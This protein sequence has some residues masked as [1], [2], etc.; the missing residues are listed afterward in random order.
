[1]RF[2]ISPVSVGLPS[3]GV[4]GLR[5]GSLAALR[6]CDRDSGCDPE[7][8]ARS[9]A[10]RQVTAQR[11][12]PLSHAAGA[13]ALCA[14]IGGALLGGPVVATDRRGGR[15]AP[16]VVI[17]LNYETCRCVIEAN[18]RRG[19]AGVPAYVRQRLLHDAVGSE[20]DGGGERPHL[21][22]ELQAYVQ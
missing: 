14:S 11:G 5:R 18:G 2:P 19:R 16:P 12:H 8:A 21:A 7:A 10:C 1:R 15:P 20:L 4:G 13:K 3:A 9:W 17:D 6:R 22:V